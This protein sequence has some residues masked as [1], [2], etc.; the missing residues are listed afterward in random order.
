MT[1]TITSYRQFLE[2]KIVI[3]D[4]S[5]FAVA[6]V[7]L[8]PEL[9]A[10][11][12]VAV[13]WAL[14]RGRALIASSFGMHK[15]R[16]QCE[17]ARQVHTRTQSR[18]LIVCPLGVR[19]Q[20]VEEDGPV[21]G[22]DWQYVRTDVE[23]AAATSPYV[24][25]NYERVRDGQIVP[26]HHELAGMSA[27]EGAI[28]QSLGTKTYSTFTDVFKSVPYRFIATAT[29]DSNDY[30]GLLGHSE[31]LGIM[32]RGQ[33]LTR[34]FKRDST[35]AGHLTL[36]PMHEHEFWMWV[37]SW[38]LFLNRPSDLGLSDDG[39]D[40]P[41]LNLHWHRIDVD[42]RRAWDQVDNQGQRRLLLN[43]SAGVREASAEKRETI[44]DRIQCMLDI[45][46][47][48][49]DRHWLLWHH[50]EA[51][52]HAI[53]KAVPAAKSVY[54]SQHDLDERERTVLEFIRGDIPILAAK[55]SMLGAGCNFQRHCADAIFVG[56]DYRFRDTIQ[57]IH[58]IYRFQQLREVNI[59]FIYAAS[60]DDVVKTFHR[61]L[62]QYQTQQQRMTEII[63]K[64][65]LSHEAMKHDLVRTIGVERLEIKQTLFTAINN[66][67]VVEVR[68]LADNSV[69]LIHT[70]IPFGNHYSYTALVDDFGYNDDDSRFWKQMDFLIPE[71]YRVLE[72][73]RVACIHVKDRILY[74]WQNRSGI[75]EVEPF[76]DQCVFAF[77]KYG[78]A[79]E[80][81]RTI[82]TD[83][84]R[85][86]ASTY[87]LGWTEMSKDATKMGSGLPEYLLTFRKPPSRPDTARADDP[88]TKDKREYTRA[89]W[90][91]DA[92]SFWRSDG[93]RPLLP[94]EL[95][96]YEAHV[97][98]LQQKDDAHNLPATFF[99][100]PPQ[101]PTH[102]VWDDIN[103]MLCLNSEQTRRQEQAHICP[104]AFDIVRRVLNLYSNPGDLVL[105]PFAGLFT[106]PYV[107]IQLGRKAIGIE[108][109]KEY[110]DAGVRYCREAE[111]QA[112]TPTLF[113]YLKTIVPAPT[114]TGA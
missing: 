113:D 90:Q 42:Q 59:H 66:D 5:G 107:A 45:M 52:R 29:P 51:E 35:H 33:A 21:M 11:A 31:F 101:S 64:Y 13:Q 78:F 28:M 112:L 103:Q 36:H 46:N 37:A 63:R 108:L 111:A 9:S 91:I 8:H 7:D 71:L 100:E 53:E 16:T 61:K 10:H 39:Y 81:R 96:D 22:M 74:G 14:D 24:I 110:Y 30:T 50:Q 27:D 72:P 41:K 23:L 75:L 89:R 69:G 76:S 62:E 40:L 95:Y 60:E 87:R 85:E 105:D 68:G 67:C 47:D 15:T 34:F 94:V 114:Q 18:F 48:N 109:K 38:A 55:P 98:R 84:V 43:P 65:G 17:I 49:P 102:W 25:T 20:F 3:S 19:H 70:S 26:A 56:V 79:Y 86:N 83:V 106:V 57:A 104:L 2:S 73:G 93:N 77:K 12:R 99:L 80:G 32:D 6:D 97:G 88:V 82:V 1:D 44:S 4:R 92:H 54:G 58:R